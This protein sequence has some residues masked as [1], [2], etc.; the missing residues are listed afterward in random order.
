MVTRI[1]FVVVHADFAEGIAAGP[2]SPFRLRYIVGPRTGSV[3]VIN[4]NLDRFAGLIAGVEVS[5]S[6]HGDTSPSPPKRTVG[7]LRSETQT[8]GL[9]TTSA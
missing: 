2:R 1:L 4:A 7:A 3:V 5:H 8:T 6:G 9:I